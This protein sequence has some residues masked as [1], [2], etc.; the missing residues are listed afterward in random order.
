MALKDITLHNDSEFKPIRLG[1]FVMIRGPSGCGKT[2]FLNLLGSIDMSTGGRI[3]IMGDVI[4]SKS[5]DTYLSKLR[6]EK[7][8]FVF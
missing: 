5:T 3:E 8:G 6:L 2:T 7:I 4:D 1:E